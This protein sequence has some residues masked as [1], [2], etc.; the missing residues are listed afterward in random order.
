MD[1]TEALRAELVRAVR[2]L[3]GTGRHRAGHRAAARSRVRRLGD[4]SRDGA[5]Q[6]ARE[7]AA[8]PRDSDHRAPRPFARLESARPRSRGRG[9]STFAS[10][11][12]S[13]PK[14]CAPSSTAGHAYGQSN[15]GEQCPVNVEF[16]SANPTGPLHVGHGRQA[17]FGDAISS[18][19]VRDRLAGL[20]RVLLQ[21]RGRADREPRA[22]RAGA[23]ARAR[24]TDRLAARGRLSRRVHPRVSPS[25][26]SRRTRAT[27]TPTT[28]TRCGASPCANCARSRTAICRRSASSSTSTSSSRRCTTTAASTTRCGGS[29]RRGTPTT[30]TARSGCARPT[31][32]TTRTASCARAS[33]D[34]HVLRARRRVPRH[35]MGA[36]VQARHQRA[37]RRSPQ[38]G[39]ARADRTAGARHR[40]PQGISGLRAAPDGDGD[41]RRRG[42]EDLQARRQLRHRARS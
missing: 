16:V 8:R 1:T 37:G 14:G 5:R 12:T 39:D 10:R 32:A 6:A 11:P 19:L 17:A 20:A 38:H 30:R 36:R 7:K 28:S 13:S 25:D 31:S 29:S 35:E 15:A 24:W 41:A 26:T 34:L 27:R 40:N 22:Q 33:G 42:G 4:Q 18:L 9:S 23:R 21:R 2:A 3:G